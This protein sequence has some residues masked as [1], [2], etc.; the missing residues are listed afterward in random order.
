MTTI[1]IE[2]FTYETIEGNPAHK[3]GPTIPIQIGKIEALSQEYFGKVFGIINQVTLTNTYPNGS[4][5]ANHNGT[6]SARQ[7]RMLQIVFEKIENGPGKNQLEGLTLEER[8]HLVLAAFLLRAGRIDESSHIDPN[9]D[10]YY[11][12]SAMIYEAYAN[13]LKASS[14]VISWVSMVILDSCKPSCIRNPEIDTTPK[15]KFAWDCLTLVH[16]LDLIRCFD[17]TD[18]DGRI[19]TLMN[20]LITPYVASPQETVNELLKISKQLC[21]ATGCSRTYDWHW[22]DPTLFAQCSSDGEKCWK[23]VNEVSHRLP[24]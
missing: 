5:R 20:S 15:Y 16:N 11:T 24:F 4:S 1:S 18:I 13:Q 7:A 23:R 10:D 3:I 6:H 2:N 12:R 9:P 17:K 19:T 21:S 14:Q 8:N 22:G